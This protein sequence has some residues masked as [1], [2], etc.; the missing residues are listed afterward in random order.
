MTGLTISG[1]GLLLFFISVMSFAQGPR[2]LSFLTA[3]V[4]LFSI[5]AG[6]QINRK[7]NKKKFITKRQ[8]AKLFGV[9]KNTIDRWLMD[10]K[11]PN[12]E[13][14]FGLRKWN[15][16]ALVALIKTKPKI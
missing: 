11:L 16:Q 9:S 5:L 1:F 15:Y 14:R 10:G 12:P 2:D 7:S 3:L 13:T 6:I 8:V 4:G